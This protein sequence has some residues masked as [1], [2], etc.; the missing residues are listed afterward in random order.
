MKTNQAY[1][2]LGLSPGSDLAAVKKAYRKK[3]KENHPDVNKH[4]DAQVRFVEINEAYEF[5]VKQLTGAPFTTYKIPKHRQPKPSKAWTPQ[6]RR[7][8]GRRATQYSAYHYER[9]EEALYDNALERIFNKYRKVAELFIIIS[10]IGFYVGTLVIPVVQIGIGG[11][12]VW[13]GIM[14][15]TAPFHRTLYQYF[16]K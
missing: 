11:I 7:R 2:L 16:K 9:F 1:Q 15:V 10:V 3:A 14:V 13:V 8:A 4:P 5:L 6:D 12:F